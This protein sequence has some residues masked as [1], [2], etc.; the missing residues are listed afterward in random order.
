[1]VFP[2]Q[3]VDDEIGRGL[4]ELFD[5]LLA[6]KLQHRHEHLFFKVRKAID[7]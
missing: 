1:M 5:A 2:Q 3:T 4:L 7:G 6:A